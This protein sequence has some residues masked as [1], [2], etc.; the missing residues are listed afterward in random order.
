MILMSAGCAAV[1][2][3][4][5]HCIHGVRPVVQNAMEL[6]LRA[7]VNMIAVCIVLA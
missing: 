1:H 6:R 5:G 3:L 7:R 4:D 2:S